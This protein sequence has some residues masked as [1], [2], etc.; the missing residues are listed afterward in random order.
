MPLPAA[1]PRSVDT[2]LSDQAMNERTTGVPSL[3]SERAGAVQGPGSGHGTA[4]PEP[5]RMTTDAP[6]LAQRAPPQPAA[7]PPD[8]PTAAP[9][10]DPRDAVQHRPQ[11]QAQNCAVA[12]APA[13]RQPVRGRTPTCPDDHGPPTA[14][15]QTSTGGTGHGAGGSRRAFK[16]CTCL[17]RFSVRGDWQSL[18]HAARDACW[19][20]PRS[21]PAVLA[22]PSILHTQPGA[23]PAHA[24]PPPAQPHLLTPHPTHSPTYLSYTRPDLVF[25]TR[26]GHLLGQALA[27]PV[28]PGALRARHARRAR[29]VA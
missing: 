27:W 24:P 26:E 22:P 4:R 16:C 18:D 13:V 25:R 1:P 7:Q 21:G 28:P 8:L 12:I 20:N 5:P 2:I 14:T 17:K 23:A 10:R 6:A 9:R 19:I 3:A 11:D 15:S 29:F